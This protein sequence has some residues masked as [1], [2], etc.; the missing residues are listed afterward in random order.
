[1][2]VYERIV[3][4]GKSRKQALIAVAIKPLQNLEG[5]MKNLRFNIAKTDR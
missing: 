1:M 3:N 4:I 2:E 5:Q